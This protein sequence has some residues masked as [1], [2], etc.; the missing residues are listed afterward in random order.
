MNI[1]DYYRKRHAHLENVWI[2]TTGF[3]PKKKCTTK[4]P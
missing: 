2:E 1:F 3:R 4:M